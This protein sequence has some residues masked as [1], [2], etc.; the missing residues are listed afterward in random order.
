MDGSRR[1]AA[2]LGEFLSA[3]RSACA[4]TVR[5]VPSIGVPLSLIVKTGVLSSRGDL[6]FVFWFPPLGGFAS[7]SG[8]GPVRGLR[9]GL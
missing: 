4:I 6:S 7:A 2:R 8:R 1:G 5:F 3:I 9:K